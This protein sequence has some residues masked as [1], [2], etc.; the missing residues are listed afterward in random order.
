MKEI[1]KDIKGYEGYYQ[2]SSLGRVKSLNRTKKHSYNSIA[3]LKEK[4]LKPQSANGYK[5]VRLCK[6]NNVK[7][8][9]V[10]RLVAEAFIPNPNNYKEIN[11]KDENKSNNNISNLEWCTHKYNINYGTRNERVSKT[12]KNTKRL[13]KDWGECNVY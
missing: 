1:W 6:G 5:F 2:I 9:I 10:H 8:K 11:H 4:Y 12:E 7:M 13:K 3:L